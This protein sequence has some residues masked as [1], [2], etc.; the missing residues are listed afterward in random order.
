MKLKGARIVHFRV[1][2]QIGILRQILAVL[3]SFDLK[4]LEL[5]AQVAELERLLDLYEKTSTVVTEKEKTEAMRALDA[6]LD[7]YISSFKGLVKSYARNPKDDVRIPALALMRTLE[8]QGWNVEDL[9]YDAESTTVSKLNTLFTTKTELADSLVRLTLKPL[10]DDVME[11][12]AKFLAM[13]GA[14]TQAYGAKS[15]ESPVEVGRQTRSQYSKLADRINAFAVVSAKPEYNNIIQ[16]L[17]PIIEAKVQQLEA[18][19]TRS[20]N[21]KQKDNE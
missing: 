21:S 3:K 13:Q 1:D 7:A 17:N 4:L 18:R 20:Q 9:S 2:E 6:E 5:E 10:W 11:A 14:R 15:E 8:E 16:L 19:Q 12:E